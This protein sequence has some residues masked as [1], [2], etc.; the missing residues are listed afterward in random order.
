M[1]RSPL[2]YHPDWLAINRQAWIKESPQEFAAHRWEEPSDG[3]RDT[4]E[5]CIVAIE[6]A[7]NASRKI[8]ELEDDWDNEGSVGYDRE[9]WERATTFL[10]SLT[11]LAFDLFGMPLTFPAISPAD[12][13]SIDL[14]WDQGD[15]GL[16]VNFPADP[17]ADAT[18]F[19]RDENGFTTGG[20]VPVTAR[21][22]FLA[23]WLTTQ[24]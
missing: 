15:C 1:Y 23:A 16:L 2:A 9:T 20:S 17:N 4:Y 14:Y 5:E 7:I 3:D 22:N 12:D 6:G 24:R 10:R 18:Y 11:R 8:L 13:G 19:G 21:P